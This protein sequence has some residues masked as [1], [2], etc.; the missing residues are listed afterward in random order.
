M[1]ATGSVLLDRL[2]RMFSIMGRKLGKTNGKEAH[3]KSELGE[4][5]NVGTRGRDKGKRGKY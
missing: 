5:E 4:G 2:L 1:L 3:K